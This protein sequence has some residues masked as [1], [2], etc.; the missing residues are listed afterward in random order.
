MKKNREAQF[1]LAG[2][3]QGRLHHMQVTQGD[4]VLLLTH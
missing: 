2:S 1:G 3:A 4:A